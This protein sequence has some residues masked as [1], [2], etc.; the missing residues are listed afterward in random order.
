MGDDA[1]NCAP[2]LVAKSGMPDDCDMPKSVA[3]PPAGLEAEMN[4]LVAHFEQWIGAGERGWAKAY[5]LVGACSATAALLVLPEDLLLSG[6]A[7]HYSPDGTVSAEGWRLLRASLRVLRHA[8]VAGCVA[9]V[10]ARALVRHAQRAFTATRA[11]PQTPSLMARADALTNREVLVIA[12]LLV[13]RLALSS[14]H[15]RDSL[16]YDELYT[17]EHF[18]TASVPRIFGIGGQFVA[19]NHILNS[20]LLKLQ[21]ALGFE[22]EA[23]LRFWSV[24]ASGLAVPAAWQLGRRAGLPS[25]H[26]VP[27]ALTITGSP[28]IELYGSQARGYALV[29]CLAP[30]ALALHLA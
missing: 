18:A 14:V 25:A 9:L 12:G 19:N 3:P 13:L 16:T 24:L 15:W 2:I 20:L 5:L 10:S 22:S 7:R 28:L 8:A 6:V 29:L 27:L 26:L 11:R 17:V 30:T 4:A 21:L 1:Q 23:G